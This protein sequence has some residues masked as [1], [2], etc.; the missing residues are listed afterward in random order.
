MLFVLILKVVVLLCRCFGINFII[1]VWFFILKFIFLKKMFRILVLVLFSVCRMID[2]G[3]L[4]WWLIC[5]YRL[6]F[7]L[8]LK[9]SYELW[10]GMICVLYRILFEEWVLFLL[11]LKNMFG[12]WCS[13]DMIIFLVL[14]IMKVLFFVMSGILFM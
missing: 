11:L 2:V 4:W 5:M 6:F 14:L 1:R 13:W 12:F 9:L 3:S 8:N 7:G 10:Y